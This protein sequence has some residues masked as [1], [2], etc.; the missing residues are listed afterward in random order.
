MSSSHLYDLNHIEKQL[1]RLKEMIKLDQWDPIRAQSLYENIDYQLTVHTLDN[2]E[3]KLEIRKI[4]RE[5]K[6]IKIEYDHNMLL[7]SANP[8]QEP[9]ESAD[10]L[11][12][13]GLKTQEESNDSLKRTQQRINDAKDIGIDINLKL[14]Q[15]TEKLAKLD[16]DLEAIGT[17]LDRTK[18]VINRIG[19]K[20]ATDKIVWLFAILIMCAIVLILLKHYNYI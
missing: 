2:P 11:M 3:N 20:I 1:Q 19:R 17:T 4:K 16:H 9:K 15:D 7:H 5:I 8:K 10:E 12:K 18:K 14:A 13:L 6:L